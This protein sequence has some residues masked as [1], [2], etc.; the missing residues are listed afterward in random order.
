MTPE[1]PAFPCPH[2][3]DRTFVKRT[4]AN[5]APASAGVVLTGGGSLIP[6]TAE[7]AS[8]VLGVEARIGVPLGLAGGLIEEVADPMYA[9]AVGL[10]LYGA[11]V[12]GAVVG[13]GRPLQSL[14]KADQR[15]QRCA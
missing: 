15:R 5:D 2:C 12:P 10:V 9:T 4:V 13:T 3:R 7:L 11:V 14:D 1:L 8:E 6:G